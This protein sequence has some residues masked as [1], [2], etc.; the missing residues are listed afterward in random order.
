MRNEKK[1]KKLRNIL[2]DI[3]A[4]KPPYYIFSAEFLVKEINKKAGHHRLANT[5]HLPQIFRQIN[6]YKKFTNNTKKPQ[7]IFVKIKGKKE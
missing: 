6:Q 3:I 1:I 5:N 4:S 2:R 7:Y